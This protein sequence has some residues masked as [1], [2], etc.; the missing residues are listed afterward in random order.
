M[1]GLNSRRG[2]PSGGL[3]PM[4]GYGSFE[5]YL[6]LKPKSKEPLMKTIAFMCVLLGFAASEPAQFIHVALHAVTVF[7]T[8]H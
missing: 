5:N 3:K 1:T 6:I 4:H 8:S 7:L 2:E